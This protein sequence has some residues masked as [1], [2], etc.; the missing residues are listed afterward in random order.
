MPTYRLPVDIVESD[1]GY[2]VK[3]PVPG[4]RPE[5]V[6]VTFSDG[7]LSIEARRSEEAERAE[8]NYVRREVAAG[9]YRRLIALPDDVQAEQIKASF[10]NGMLTV[11]VPR[12]PR[13]E[14]IRI[15][16]ERG[17]Q[18]SEGSR[19]L[20]GKSEEGEGRS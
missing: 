16:V 4:F 7:V 2:T 17:E 13:P 19:Q 15:Q 3:A 18:S 10:D 1:S 5:D 20:T 11:E 14:P 12:A 8:G 6:E 9:N